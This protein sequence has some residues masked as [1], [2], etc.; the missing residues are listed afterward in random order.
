MKAYYKVTHF[1]TENANAWP[2]NMC[3][4]PIFND[5]KYVLLHFMCQFGCPNL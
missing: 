1:F 3:L 4:H 5:C 2:L